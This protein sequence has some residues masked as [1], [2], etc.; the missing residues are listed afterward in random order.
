MKINIDDIKC[1][2]IA[3]ISNNAKKDKTNACA[4]LKNKGFY[5][6]WKTSRCVRQDG[7]IVVVYYSTNHRYECICIVENFRKEN[8]NAI[9]DL[10]L[11]MDLEKVN[12]ADNFS[13]DNLKKLGFPK[14]NGPVNYCLD[15]Y[16]K[17]CNEIKKIIKSYLN[18]GQP[19]NDYPKNPNINNYS[20]N[21]ILYGPPG[22]GKTYE[23][24]AL[25]LKIIGEKEKVDIDIQEIWK[26][27][28]IT[29][30][31]RKKLLKVFEEYK[32]NGQIEFVTFH[33]SYSYEEFVEGIKPDLEEENES[34][35]YIV[36]DGVLKEIAQKALINLNKEKV[37]QKE[38]FDQ[39]LNREIVEKV[40]NEEKLEIPLKRKKIYIYDVTSR[41]IKFEK[42]NGDKRHSL[43]LKTLRKMYEDENVGNYIHG[44]LQPY[45]EGVLQYLLDKSSKNQKEDPKNFILIIDEINRGNISKIFGELITLIE[46]NKRIG[47]DE[48][49]TVTLPYSKES[50]GIPNNLYI[51]GTMNTADRSIALL[52]TALRR[53]FEFVEMMPDPELL[54]EVDGVDLKELLSKINERIK[55]LYDRDHT[56]GHSYFMNIE[57][58]K[59]LQN[60]FRNKIIPLLQEYF[61]GDWQKIR[62]VLADNQIKDE[63]LQFIKEIS[64]DYASL[65]GEDGE[66]YEEK[67][68]YKINEDAFKE[69]NSYIKIYKKL[70][71]DTSSD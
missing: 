26:K 11:L 40:V 12:L 69:K 33:Q 49:L 1:E 43:A 59:D 50:F 32:N 16:E 8:K 46:E 18:R 28:R 67:K 64:S 54:E 4:V 70:G 23:T 51:I 2:E 42:E 61:Y 53:R 65:F 45:Y 68:M 41:S 5:Q 27:N 38:D 39:I 52:D 58:F 31:E 34:L 24:I 57:S 6:D 35:S 44:G 19:E 22:T 47:A 3:V 13:L 29:Q 36:E 14:N 48:E 66:F 20:R 10:R 9:F 71:D 7:Q 17:I 56:I 60:A 62:L 63:S 30:V 55:Y 37:S 25:A 21:T 15:S